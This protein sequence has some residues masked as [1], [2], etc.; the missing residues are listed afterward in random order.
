MSNGCIWLLLLFLFCVCAWFSWIFQHYFKLFE[1]STEEIIQ[2]TFSFYFNSAFPQVSYY[3]H[4]S[5]LFFSND[6]KYLISHINLKQALAFLIAN[7]MFLS[8]CKILFHT[9]LFCAQPGCGCVKW[10]GEYL[11]RASN[12]NVLKENSHQPHE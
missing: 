3:I 7:I 10:A 9:S 4:L 8:S 12:W 5:L 1:N 2:F 6:W 11:N